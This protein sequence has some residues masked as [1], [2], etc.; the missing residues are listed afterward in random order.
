MRQ[1]PGVPVVIEAGQIAQRRVARSLEA[2]DVLGGSRGPFR[3]VVD[4]VVDDQRV[5]ELL[6]RIGVMPIVRR[7]GTPSSRRSKSAFSSGT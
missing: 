5:G 4:E 7:N 3:G 1:H 2:V 6:A